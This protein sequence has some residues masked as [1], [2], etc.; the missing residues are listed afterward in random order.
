VNATPASAAAEL[1]PRTDTGNG[2]LVLLIHPAG[3]DSTMRGRLHDLLVKNS[4]FGEAVA[5]LIN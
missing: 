5:P 2:P 4:R 3:A 1:E